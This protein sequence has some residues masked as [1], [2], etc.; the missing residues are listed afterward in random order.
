MGCA[1]HFD[2]VTLGVIGR[3]V[4]VYLATQRSLRRAE[5]AGTLT[6]GPGSDTMTTRER[7]NALKE[8]LSRGKRAQ[9][10]KKM[11]S[12]SVCLSVRPFLPPPPPPH[13]LSL[14]LSPSL[15]FPLCLFVLFCFTCSFERLIGV[16]NVFSQ[17][18]HCKRSYTNTKT[19]KISPQQ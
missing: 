16:G 19:R 10:W 6:A 5:V 12:L 2:I 11:N 7:R 1:T 15:D 3:S 13:L 4:S 8:K 18:S 17:Y 9:Q 14:S